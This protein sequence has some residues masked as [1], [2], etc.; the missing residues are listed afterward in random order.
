MYTGR[1]CSIYTKVCVYIMGWTTNIT[2]TGL[3]LSQRADVALY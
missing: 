3:E 2:I 1:I